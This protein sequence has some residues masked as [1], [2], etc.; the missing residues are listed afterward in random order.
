MST[1]MRV[2]VVSDNSGAIEIEDAKLIGSIVTKMLNGSYSREEISGGS[3]I[4][5]THSFA[6][7]Y[8]KSNRKIVGGFLSQRIRL[9]G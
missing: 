7:D 8:Q 9:G 2:G 5:R 4:V 1:E 6:D 3:T